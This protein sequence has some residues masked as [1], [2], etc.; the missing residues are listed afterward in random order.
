MSYYT[1]EY[2]LAQENYVFD[3]AAHFEKAIQEIKKEHG[4][5]CMGNITSFR[6]D[7]K[8][9]RCFLSCCLNDP[10]IPMVSLLLPTFMRRKQSV[11]VATS[12][13]LCMIGENSHFLSAGGRHG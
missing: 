1:F 5:F 8:E 2:P 12:N 4:E 9:R 6:V 10:E 3:I 13:G 7:F 11:I